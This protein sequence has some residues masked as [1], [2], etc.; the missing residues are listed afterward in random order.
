MACVTN[1]GR[2]HLSVASLAKSLLSKNKRKRTRK[3]GLGPTALT[4]QLQ[5]KEKRKPEHVGAGQRQI[6]SQQA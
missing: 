1:C 4:A 2:A 6:A 3:A 5:E